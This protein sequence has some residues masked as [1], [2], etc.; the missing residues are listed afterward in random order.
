M[1]N[2]DQERWRRGYCP[3]CGGSPDFAYLDKERGSRWLVCSRCDTEW[4]FQRLQCPYCNTQDQNQLAYL[5]DNDG[6]YRLY[7]CDNCQQYLKAIDLQRAK[8]EV[9][10]YLERLFT[11]YLDAQAREY[12]YSRSAR[13]SN[14]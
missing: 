10:I 7:V 1:G 8:G 2:V 9:I 11:L 4:L 5:T 3:V 14:G 6:R 12:G 13:P